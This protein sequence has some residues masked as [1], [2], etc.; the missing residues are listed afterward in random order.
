MT[1]VEARMTKEIRMTKDER[2]PHRCSSF[3]LRHSFV[4]RHSSFVI[5]A[6]C[7]CGSKSV[8]AAEKPNV[9]FILCD[10]LGYGDIGPFGNTVLR[11]PNLDRM[12]REGRKFTHFYSAAPVCSPSRA[13]L[14]TGCYPLRVGLPRGE[15]GH[16]VLTPVCHLGIAA[17]EWTMAEM[18]R[19]QGYATMCIGKWHLGD[20]PP[21]LPTHNGFDDYLG[22]PYSEDMVGNKRPGWPPLP[23]VRGERV[24][25]APTDRDLLTQKYTAEAVRYIAA[26]RDRPFFLYLPHAV[27]GSEAVGFASPEFQGR[28]KNS[29]YGDSVEE[30][31]WST[32]QIFDALKEAGIDDRTL[33]IWTSDNG[34]VRRVPQLG[35]NAPL[36]G[37]GYSTA[38]GGMR[39]PLLAHWPGR[40]PPDSET[41][42]LTTMMDW[43]PTLAAIVGASLPRDRVIDG[44][45]I[46][47][48]LF[49]EPDAKSPHRV[50]FYYQLDQLQ[51]VR[52]GNWKLHLP[53][54]ETLRLGKPGEARPAALYDVVADPA[55]ARDVAVQHPDVVAELTKLVDEARDDIGDRGRPGRN[56]RK[57]GWV[58]NPVP[59]VLP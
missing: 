43:L 23:L 25:D 37:W 2:Q 8:F 16:A 57:P 29:R 27:P 33:V 55:E 14:M 28:S 21:F 19:A 53:L 58:D 1:N 56:A 35:T 7:L 42:E 10:N 30:M 3:V 36:G 32:G 50:F 13:A 46:R 18:F 54:T 24:I 59:L 40:I 26:H 39:M 47:P 17:D 22:I 15:T 45:D 31:D 48:L 9:V 38:E 12:A 4:I 11:T 34:A 6:L 44:R 41:A 51:A 5:F 49:G 20:Q 52:A